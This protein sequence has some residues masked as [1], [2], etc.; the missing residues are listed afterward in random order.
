MRD[1]RR[2]L[3]W[4]RSIDL[5]IL[6]HGL[7][8]RLPHQDRFVLG[9]QPYKAG[10]SIPNNI[11]EG[12][13]KRSA[14]DYV[15]FLEISLGSALEVQSICVITQRLDLFDRSKQTDLEDRIAEIVRMRRSLIQH[16]QR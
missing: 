5:A 2:L 12:C 7:V 6:I 11:A 10:L 8:H 9:H 15:R 3:V 16:N 1:F 14:K 13:A 4:Q